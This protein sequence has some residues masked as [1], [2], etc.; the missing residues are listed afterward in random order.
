MELEEWGSSP[1]NRTILSC[2]RH[3]EVH[4]L[5]REVTSWEQPIIQSAGCGEIWLPM[6]FWNDAPHFLFRTVAEPG[7]GART[8]L[9]PAIAI[10]PGGTAESGGFGSAFKKEGRVLASCLQSEEGGRF[11]FDENQYVIVDVGPVMK[12]PRNYHWLSL[13]QIRELLGRGGRFTNEA[14]SALSLLLKW[15]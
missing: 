11:L 2:V 14:R 12:P 6:G 1:S 4:S 15:L 3:V 13:A 9:T 7:F 5:S 10:E 8:E